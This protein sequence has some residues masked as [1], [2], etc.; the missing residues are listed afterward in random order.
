MKNIISI[1]GLVVITSVVL[2]D[3]TPMD[4]N[5]AHTSELGWVDE[6]IKAIIPSRIGISDQEIN[7]LAEP[8]KFKRDINASAS[9]LSKYF[10]L[11]S[12]K[13]AIAIPKPPLTV[14]LI[15]N[16]KAFISKKWYQV[17]DTVDGYTVKSVESSSVTLANKKGVKVLS[18]KS[19]NLN[20][21]IKTK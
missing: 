4:I 13:A 10:S 1:L 5:Q 8:F 7:S 6:Q 14:T 18:I 17:G 3:V 19:D 9:D 11:K 16:K 2:A 12:H 15:I 20:L 21:K